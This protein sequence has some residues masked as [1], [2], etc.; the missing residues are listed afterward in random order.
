VIPALSG[1][2]ASD[3]TVV[4]GAAMLGSLLMHQLSAPTTAALLA[5]VRPQDFWLISR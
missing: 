4:A 2:R 5:Q 1:I 3:L